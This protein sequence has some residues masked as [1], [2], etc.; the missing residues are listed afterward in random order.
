MLPRNS[1]T[2]CVKI[3]VT[4]G[5]PDSGDNKEMMKRNRQWKMKHLPT[6]MY[7]GNEEDDCYIERL[8]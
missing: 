6:F 2:A 8:F 3:S 1:S 7:N 4:F 5:R